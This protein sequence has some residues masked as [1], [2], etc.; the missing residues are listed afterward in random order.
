MPTA[1]SVV[2]AMSVEELRLYS[3]I[4]IEISLEMLDGATAKI[5]GEANNVVYLTRD[6]FAVRLC[7]PVPS[8]VK[9][10]LL[11]GGDLFHLYFE[12]GDWELF[13]HV[14]P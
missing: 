13:V 5:V 4:P 14:G 11:T 8:L 1:S 3:Q 12:A 6:Q 2:V 10:F 9:Q 7:L